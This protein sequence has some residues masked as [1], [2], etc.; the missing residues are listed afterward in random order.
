LT[1]ESATLTSSV[2]LTLVVSNSNFVAAEKARNPE[3]PRV[4]TDIYFVGPRLDPVAVL[5]SQ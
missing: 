4:R 5:R 2:P 1:V 3:A